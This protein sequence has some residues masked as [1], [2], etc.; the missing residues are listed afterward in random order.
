MFVP[1]RIA[2]AALI[3]VAAVAV[4]IGLLGRPSN[5]VA[6]PHPSAS[7]ATSALES[8]AAASPPAAV[9]S[10]QPSGRV[11]PSTTLTTYG[12]ARYGYTIGYPS[13]WK[14]Q[15]ASADL[16]STDYPYDFAVGV[17]YFSATAPTTGDPGLIVAGPTVSAGTTLDTWVA[18][19]K[20]LQTSEHCNAP[21]SIEST[22]LGGQAAQLLTWNDCPAFLLWA[23]TLNSGRAYH[24]IWI[25]EFAKG[26]AALQASDKALFQEILAS[27]SFAKP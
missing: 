26:N 16:R 5:N 21:D 20:G 19:I 27:F 10:I 12:S 3:V 11:D 24:V 14:N 4:G 8:T 2:A 18:T 1:I 9:A 6:A 25:D 23:G 17:D 22:Q 13:N 15:P 7:A